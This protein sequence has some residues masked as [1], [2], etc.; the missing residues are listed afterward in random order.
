MSSVPP[1]QVRCS[2]QVLGR[3]MLARH[4]RTQSRGFHRQAAST[5]TAGIAI[6]TNSP[7]CQHIWPALLLFFVASSPRPVR[8]RGYT[9]HP[10]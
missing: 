4:R 9:L 8:I 5:T 6:A 10:L 2:T 3:L 1:V 7:N